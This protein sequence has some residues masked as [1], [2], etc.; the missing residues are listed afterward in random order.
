ML[1]RTDLKNCITLTSKDKTLNDLRNQYREIF[2][3]LP[4]F[5]IISYNRSTQLY[6]IHKDILTDKIE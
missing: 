3:K 1:S 6:D 4:D 2:N 5:N